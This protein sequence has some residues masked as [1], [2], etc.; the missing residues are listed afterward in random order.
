MLKH[1]LIRLISC[2][3]L[4]KNKKKLFKIKYLTGINNHG[5]NNRCIL[6]KENKKEVEVKYIKGLSINFLGNNSTVKIYEPYHFSNCHLDIENDAEIILKGSNYLIQN[7]VTDG[8]IRSSNLIIE[9]NCSFNGVTLV[10]QEKGCD[11]TVCKDCMFGT[12]IILR[13][14]DSHLIYNK[15]T[16]NVLNSPENIFIGSH[17][18]IGTNSTILKGVRIPNNSIIGMN[19]VVTR[20]YCKNKNSQEGGIYAGNPAKLVRRLEKDETWH[21][22]CKQEYFVINASNPHGCRESNPPISS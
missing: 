2:L 15:T 19:S 7:M 22:L 21:R 20:S 10:M 9:E 16:N 13:P 12:N 14:T 1:I 5:H 11:I 18:W 8:L 4:N 3:I 17:C 6:V